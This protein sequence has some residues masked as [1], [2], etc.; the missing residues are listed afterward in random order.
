MAIGT[1]QAATEISLKLYVLVPSEKNTIKEL[2][3]IMIIIS[4]VAIQNGPYKSG[5]SS[6][7]CR[8]T[9]FNNNADLI[10]ANISSY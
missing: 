7:T 1:R 3:A 10:L 5:L 2:E 8:N 6:I 4:V 9:G